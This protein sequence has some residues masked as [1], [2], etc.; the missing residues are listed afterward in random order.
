MKNCVDT[1]CFT[2]D[3]IAA[4]KDISERSF[5]ACS[6]SSKELRFMVRMFNRNMNAYGEITEA[7]KS[8]VISSIR[9]TGG[10][11]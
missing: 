7:V 5:R 10:L 9:N 4:I 8:H 2:D 1:Q 6:V 3:E 11:G